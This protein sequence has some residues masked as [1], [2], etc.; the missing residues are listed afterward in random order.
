MGKNVMQMTV[1]LAMS[2]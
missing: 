1:I 2:L